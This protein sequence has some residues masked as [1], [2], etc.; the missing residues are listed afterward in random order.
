MRKLHL[1]AKFLLFLPIFIVFFLLNYDVSGSNTVSGSETDKHV[2]FISSY[3]ESFLSIPD[4]IKGMREV[5]TPLNIQLDVEYMDTKRFDTKENERLF[6][7][8][9]KYKLHNLKPYDAIIVGDDNALQFAMD[10]QNDLFHGLPIVFL[11]VNDY[12]RAKRAWDNKYI[13]GII[14][15]MSLKDN[16]E[17]GLKINK[18]AKKVAAIVDDTLTGQGD[19][20]QFYKNKDIFK[21]LTFEEIN[22]SDY[23]FKE[24]EDVLE[25]IGEDTIL[26][27]LSMYTD[28]TGA[29]LTIPEAVDL[30]RE[31]THIPVLRAEVGGV[32]QG[33]LGGKMVSYLEA[34]RIAAKIVN[35]VFD[36]TPV[37]SINIIT[38][39][40]SVYTFDY[41]LI[42]KY[43]IDKA[44]LPKDAV[45]INKKESFFQVYKTLVINT[46]I[47]L[48]FL[49]A[50]V[51]I[52]II[53]N[54][55]QRKTEKA[56]QESHEEL[57]QTFEELTASEEE[58]RAQYD[59]IQEHTE[60][61]ETLNQKYSIAIESTDSAVWEYNLDTR[62]MNISPQFISDI[63]KSIKEQEE[64]QRVFELLLD[65]VEQE[66][67]LKEFHS[68]KE[69]LKDEIHI[70]ISIT[71][72]DNKKRWLLVRGKGLKD[73]NGNLR[74]IHG[75]ILDITR[76]KGQ[77]EYIEYLAKHDYLTD[78]PNRR[79]FMNKLEEE[80][81]QKKQ[82]SILLLDIDDFK[83]INDTLGHI[84]G[85]K[86]LQEISQKL[87]GL[88]DDKLFISRFGGDEFLILISGE[89]GSMQIQSYVRKIMQLFDEPLVLYQK[90]N[91]VKFS[92]GITRFPEDSDNINQLLMNADTAMYRVK[93]GG[94]NNFMFF[95]VDMLD[96]LKHRTDIEVILREAI[97]NDGFSLAYQPQ[98]NVITGEIIGFEALLR[99][100]NYSIPPNKFINIAEET[101]LIKEIGR[102]VTKQAIR[103]IK[104]WQ[105]KGYEPKSVAVNFS[106]KQIND[107]GYLAFLRETLDQY[108]VAP[109]YLEIEITESILLE[110]DA[111][112]IVFLNQLKKIGVRM[113]LDDFG[114]GYSSLNYLTFIPVDKIKLDKTLCE[115]FLGLDNLRVMNSL[116]ALAHSLEL[117][118]IAEGIEQLEQFKRLKDGGCDY[119]QG[120][121]FSKPLYED[122]I[123][124]IYNFNFLEH[125]VL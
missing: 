46:L 114:T 57:T 11:G 18:K 54:L 52:L 31:H 60:E 121:L 106:S 16:I 110:Q 66:K 111:N 38:D 118:I 83:S 125:I 105:E 123:E 25:S 3:S 87:S 74:I 67:L 37:K 13:T 40:P 124:E 26:L 32:G 55:K 45:Y 92:I 119:I 103:Q 75:I 79:E 58:L 88:M 47:V 101:G 9:L 17:L 85:D 120:Y 8:L 20:V 90:E 53:D 15:E 78:L 30:I 10:Y 116:I 65:P 19:W 34:G 109:E 112:T 107:Y 86:M 7:N 27:Y 82:G 22:A 42:K 63:N 72:Y 51:I 24:M 2:L 89:D 94:K 113:A 43:K 5:F 61:I 115:K 44:V 102:W 98:V 36:G 50:I 56:L 96:E 99:L 97:K 117:V 23:T 91:F 68:Y 12:N 59:T 69:G 81:S 70:K 62:V 64:I 108:Q 122:E 48:L 14:E 21:Q 73:S 49:V 80:L 84:Y 77:E 76:S 28:K 71:D 1:S 93:H 33:I 95:N 29:T 39:S 104:I 6:Y 4:E 41:N 100:K 35:K